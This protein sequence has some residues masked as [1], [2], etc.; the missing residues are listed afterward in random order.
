MRRLE[1]VRRSVAGKSVERMSQRE[2]V[3]KRMPKKQRLE[4][5][6]MTTTPRKDAD[7]S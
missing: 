1:S 4:R 7:R 2:L 3:S 5:L 6:K